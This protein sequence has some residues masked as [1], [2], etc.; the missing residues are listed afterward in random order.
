MIPPEI[1]EIRR[2]VCAQH[3]CAHSL[4][5]FDPCSSCPAGHWGP[6]DCEDAPMPCQEEPKREPPGLL[7]KLA[8]FARANVEEVRAIAHGVEPLTKEEIDR[9]LDIC[10][11]CPNYTESGECRLCG[12][13][14]ARKA[15]YRS[16]RC[17]DNP[18]RW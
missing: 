6:F 4:D 16:Q 3:G 15:P 10:K 9:R 1:A 12:C 18:P 17:S 2:D 8:S 14:M 13:P 7:K 11:A 5:Y